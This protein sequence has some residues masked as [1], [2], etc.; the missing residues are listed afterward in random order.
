MERMSPERIAEALAGPHQAVLS[1]GRAEKGPLAVP[2][3]Y[4]FLEGRFVFVTSPGSLHGKLMTKRGRATF[5]V[6]Y[7]RCEGR[8]LHQWYVIAEGP[9]RFADDDPV[10]HVRA[11]LAK[12]RGPE[13]VDEWIGPSFPVGVLTAVLE[14]ERISG[15]EY[16]ETL[17]PGVLSE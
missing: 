17:G 9:V 13:Y 12:D 3:S 4:R 11:T 7:D 16:R 14:P 15:W 10:P 2:M 6:Q 5:T 1:V 8:R